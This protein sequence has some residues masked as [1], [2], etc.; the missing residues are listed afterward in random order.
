MR[1]YHATAL[2]AAPPDR[3]WAELLGVLRWP[4]WL[5]TVTSVQPLGA[6]PLAVGARYRISQPRLR[7]AVWS[8]VQFDPQ[9]SFAWE[10]RSPGVR[11]LANHSLSSAPGGSTHVALQIDFSGP[12]SVLVLWQCGFAGFHCGCKIEIAAVA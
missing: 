10:S 11:A 5:P 12:L 3:V 8:V 4:E 6:A 9:R 1:T 2:I 7:P